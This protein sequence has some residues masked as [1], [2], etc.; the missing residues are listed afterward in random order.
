MK[1]KIPKI[2]LSVILFLFALIYVAKFSGPNI[3][4]LY[5][6][7]GI[8]DCQKIPI[9]C[10][11]PGEEI[12]N[13][14]I[15]KEAIAESILYR[16]PKMSLSIPK[17]FTVVKE[18]VK[19]VYYKKK[20]RRYPGAIIYL[21]YEEPGFFVNLFPQFKKE[22]IISNYEFI[23]RTMYARIGSIKD[24][25]DA[26][27]VIMKG[28]FIPD[29]GEQRNVK[30]VQFSLRD[31]GGF[32]NYNL[33]SPDNYFDCDIINNRGDF[34]KIYIKDKGARLDLEKVF[35]IISTLHKTK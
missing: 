3:L 18:T 27:F 28:I 20:K 24:L 35:A 23:K 5:I 19:K 33:S 10:M 7:S 4:K 21:L 6:E 9:L 14:P 12:R 1:Q 2:I 30:L 29:L 8:G 17:G 22:G 25:Q 16:F 15:N 11:A 26:F 31:K 13:P 34:F 32:I